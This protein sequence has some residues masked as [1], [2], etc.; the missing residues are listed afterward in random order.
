MQNFN[1]YLVRSPMDE[2]WGFY[3]TTVGYSKI[4]PNQH[5]PIRKD[6]PASHTFT[7]NK[8]RILDDYYLI[9]ISQ[10]QGTFE[11][12]G[13]GAFD[14]RAGTCFF[15]YPGMWHR[16]KPDPHSGW[17]EYWVGFRGYYPDY[18]MAQG[19]LGKKNQFIYVGPHEYLQ[20][21]FHKLLECVRASMAGYHQ[22]I[23]GITLEILGLVNS[24]SLHETPGADPSGRFI[25]QAK[26]RMRESIE[27]PIEIQQLLQDIPVS[28]SK[29]RKDFKKT[30]GL[31]P[32]QYYLD[33][34][35]NKAKELLSTTSLSVNEVAYYTGFESIFYFS[36]LFK[37]KNGISPKSYRNTLPG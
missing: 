1:K 13:T 3:I 22:V 36:R 7:W 37:K 18:L 26:F 8:G 30:T 31:S 32:N 33:I 19:F 35:L 9:F 4:E 11:S 2:H 12:S 16:Y 28:Y 29:F 15:L 21:L 14:I 23:S 34:R 6:H 17:E 27:N 25:D 20:Q 24:I 5:Y 10:G